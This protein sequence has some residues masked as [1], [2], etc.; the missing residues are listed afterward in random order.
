MEA[1]QQEDSLAVSDVGDPQRKIRV[2]SDLEGTN[3]QIIGL[4]GKQSLLSCYHILDYPDPNG[5]YGVRERDVLLIPHVQ[6][7]LRHYN[8]RHPGGEF[9][10]VKPLMQIG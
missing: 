7:A 9:D 4:R 3:S 2:P 1:I 8:A 10:V 6:N 5:V